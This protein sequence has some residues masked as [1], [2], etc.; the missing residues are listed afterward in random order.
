MERV[1]IEIARKGGDTI[2][3]N[4]LVPLTMS[5]DQV[6]YWVAAHWDYVQ[7]ISKSAPTPSWL[8]LPYGRIAHA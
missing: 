8:V 2:H 1:H 4:A 7:W 6:T 3:L 5:E